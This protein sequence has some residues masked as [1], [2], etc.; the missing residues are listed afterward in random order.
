M[1][2]LKPYLGRIEKD[3]TE[4]KVGYAG[5]KRKGRNNPPLALYFNALGA[6]PTYLGKLG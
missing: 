6:P 2:F 1:V 3:M 4:P 5:S